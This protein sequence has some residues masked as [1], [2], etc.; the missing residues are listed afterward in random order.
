MSLPELKT[1]DYTPIPFHVWYTRNKED[2][3]KEFEALKLFEGDEDGRDC[4]TC[5]G[6]GDQECDLGHD[7]ECPDCEGSGKIQQSK[8]EALHEYA[9]N[10]YRERVKLDTDKL[11]NYHAERYTQM[12]IF[13]DAAS[14]KNV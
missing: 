3:E 11:R 6:R 12:G 2:L 4:E 1:F 13:G 5:D 9:N 8:D 7:H 10:Q 14:F